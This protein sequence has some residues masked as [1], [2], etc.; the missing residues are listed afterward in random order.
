MWN[1]SSSSSKFDFCTIYRAWRGLKLALQ[2]PKVY[3]FA[4]FDFCVLLG[5]GFVQFFPTSVMVIFFWLVVLI[6]F[7]PFTVWLKQWASQPLS[8]S[9]LLRTLPNVDNTCLHISHSLNPR[10]PWILAA[11]FCIINA[12]HAGKST[13]VCS[14]L[15]SDRPLYMIRC[16]WWTV[17]AHN[18]VVVGRH[19]WLHHCTGHDVCWWSLCIF[20]LNGNW[21]RWR[22]DNFG[23]G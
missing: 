13:M 19:R 21:L 4:L 2:D 17:L 11:V 9:Y 10:P 1:S 23:V 16:D 12:R 22:L 7:V 14:N 5:L 3:I 8:H 20:V 18:R 15:L 6:F